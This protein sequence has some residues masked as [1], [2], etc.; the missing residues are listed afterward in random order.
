MDCPYQNPVCDLSVLELLGFRW[1]VLNGSS[2]KWLY[3]GEASVNKIERARVIKV[4]QSNGISQ[5]IWSD[6]LKETGL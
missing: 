1:S 3:D 5:L 6:N 2:I 4:S